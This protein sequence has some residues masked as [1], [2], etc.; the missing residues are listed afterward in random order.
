MLPLMRKV[1]YDD[2]RSRASSMN[3]VIMKT[4]I[5]DMTVS[6]GVTP[7]TIKKRNV[8][9]PTHPPISTGCLSPKIKLTSPSVPSSPTKTV[10]SVADML[11]IDLLVVQDSSGRLQVPAKHSR[12]LKLKTRLEDNPFWSAP[13][14]VLNLHDL[15]AYDAS[16]KNPPTQFKP[17]LDPTDGPAVTSTQIPDDCSENT[18]TGVALPDSKNKQDDDDID[19]GSGLSAPVFVPLAN[20]Y[21]FSA[22]GSS[23]KDTSSSLRRESAHPKLRD[24]TPTKLRKHPIAKLD[25]NVYD[26]SIYAIDVD[27]P[28]L[29]TWSLR[30]ALPLADSRLEESDMCKSLIPIKRA[31]QLRPVVLPIRVASCESSTSTVSTDDDHCPHDMGNAVADCHSRGLNEIIAQLDV[32][33]LDCARAKGRDCSGNMEEEV[34]D[35]IG[36]TFAM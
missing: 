18:L 14:S 32:N 23:S 10:C 11:P 9:R 1:S 29:E 21:D 5:Y 8:K 28:R 3:K 12:S 4:T 7:A 35:N 22:Y 25:T 17:F 6:V 24:A 33:I 16:V 20:F 13:G 31:S 26:L 27:L 2:L 15:G 30:S 34:P 19:V 36:G